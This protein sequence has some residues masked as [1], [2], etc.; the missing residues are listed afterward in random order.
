MTDASAVPAP[1]GPLA[2][3]VVIEMA[4]TMQVAA[5]A[6][7]IETAAA[8][9]W[10]LQREVARASMRDVGLPVVQHGEGRPLAATLE[11]VSAWPRRARS[12]G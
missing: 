6:R 7:P 5:R 10:L 1:Q 11:E 9:L 4:P 2:D 3:L 12:L 8:H